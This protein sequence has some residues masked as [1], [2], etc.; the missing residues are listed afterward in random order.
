[1]YSK[2]MR[3]TSRAVCDYTRHWEAEGASQGLVPPSGKPLKLGVGRLHKTKSGVLRQKR[4]AV[5]A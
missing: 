1:M 2:K 3:I 4:V 5:A